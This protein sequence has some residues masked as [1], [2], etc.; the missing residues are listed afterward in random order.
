LQFSIEKIFLKSFTAVNVFNFWSIKTLDSEL[1]SYPD[2]QLGKKLD[3]D[4]DPDPQLGKMLDQDQ[5]PNPYPDP[6]LGKMLDQD[7]DLQLGKN[8]GSIRIRN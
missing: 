1:D 7:P 2:P 3:Q 4:R 6:Q 8:A 5:D